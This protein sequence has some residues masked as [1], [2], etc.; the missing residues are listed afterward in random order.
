MIVATSPRLERLRAAGMAKPAV[1]R[2]DLPVPPES[3]IEC[4][5]YDGEHRELGRFLV[6]AADCLSQDT[7]L[8]RGWYWSNFMLAECGVTAFPQAR[9]FGYDRSR[10]LSGIR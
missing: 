9:L 7:I 3:T 2:T 10:Q 5:A 1:E 8:W 4:T 6:R